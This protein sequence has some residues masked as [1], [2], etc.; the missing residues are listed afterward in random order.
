MLRRVFLGGVALGLTL[1]FAGSFATAGEEKSVLDFKVK[2]IDGKEVNLANFKGK[3][4]LV[5]NVASKCGLTPQYDGLEALYE[6]YKDKGLVIL[7][8]PANEFGA[9]EPGTDSEIK[10]FCSSKY[11]VTFP[12]FSKIVVKGNG[13]HPLYKFLTSKDTNPHFA[14]EIAWNFNKFLIDGHGHVVGRF[15][16]KTAPD[17]AKMVKAIEDALKGAAH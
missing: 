7:G 15:E 2:D 6:K 10:Q 12:M 14:G 3:T 11:N 8:F 5:V 13:I 9:Q 1:S 4:I 17:D 16:P